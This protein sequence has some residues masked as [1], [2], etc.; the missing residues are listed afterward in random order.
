MSAAGDLA[1]ALLTF[2]VK[3][4][5]LMQALQERPLLK[6]LDANKETF[7]GGKDYISTAVQGTMMSDTTGFFQG[8]SE[9]QLFEFDQAENIRRAQVAW[10]EVVANLIITWTE[11]KK[12]GITVTN[13]G[14]MKNHSN[15]EAVRIAGGTFKARIADF[16]ESWAIS[17][18]NMLWGDGSGSKQVPGITALLTDTPNTGTTAGLVRSDYTWWRHR[19][20]L[21][22]LAESANTGPAITPSRTDQTLTRKLRSELRQLMRWGGRPSVALCGSV[23]LDALAD[24]VHEKGIYTQE[25]FVNNGKNDIGM[26]DISMKG[27]GTF[28]Y[29]PWL[30]SNNL[31]SRCYVIDPRRLRLRP[32]ANEENKVLDPER[33]YNAAVFLRSMTWTGGLE[34]TQLNCHGVYEVAV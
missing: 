5:P 7:P 15:A 28:R 27:L 30:D 26:T 21:T 19:A 10:Y 31:S 16:T 2:Y 13:D 12:D 34:V 29:D 32:M 8:Y 23:F 14:S 18:N 33:P 20:F 22:G 6:I 4:G 9:D 1:N 24:E 25:G 11:L 17:M 3:N